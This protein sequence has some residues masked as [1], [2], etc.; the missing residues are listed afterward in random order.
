MQC[1]MNSAIRIRV[2]GSGPVA[3]RV[4][5]AC[6]GA[7]F[8][9]HTSAHGEAVTVVVG[10][11]ADV[12]GVHAPV[13]LVC[14]DFGSAEQGLLAAGAVSDV[15]SADASMGE[16]GARIR[17][18]WL[19]RDEQLADDWKREVDQLLALIRDIA[20]V[21]GGLPS[22]LHGLVSRLAEAAGVER[23]SLVLVDSPNA[24][25]GTV[26]ATSDAA[27][28]QEIH[29][30]LADYPEVREAL[31]TGEPVIVADAAHH[32]LLDGVRA[33]LAKAQVGAVAVF[34]L[35][36]GTDM[37][38][39]L[40][41]RSHEM[42]KRPER[43]RLATTAAVATAIAVRHGRL[44]E[45]V[46]DESARQFER[47][48]DLIEHLSDGVAVIDREGRIVLLNPAGVA[49]FG[50]PTTYLG[51][52]VLDVVPPENPA[53]LLLMWRAINRGG[54]V[55]NADI[56]V[57]RANGQKAIVAVSA[58]Q[59]RRQRLVV[60]SFRDVTEQR[61][62]ERELR[63]TRDFLE[64]VIDA[65]SDAIVASDL[66]GNLL[67]FNRAAG[68]IFGW[69]A[70]QARSDITVRDL[71]PSGGA[72]EIMRLLREAP[73]G[74]IESERIVGRTS[75][76]DDFPVEL[77]AAIIYAGGQEVASVGV[78]RDLRERVRVEGELSRARAKL[79]NAEKHAAIT[80][81]AGATAHELNQP[82]TVL[83]GHVELL[84][85]RSLDGSA[86][87]SFE[88]IGAETERMAAI[89]KRIARLTRVETMPY[90]GERLI[91]DLERSSDPTSD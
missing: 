88:A 56:T 36:D 20:T 7:A 16:L 63:R 46:R 81:L 78:L 47:Y 61:M 64:R 53:E 26:V 34:P 25:V 23:C 45:A 35:R 4:R 3:T 10:Q 91:A 40:M 2:A 65:S 86:R 83:L 58:G 12:E 8:T 89:V 62:T 52:R 84:R 59:L 66:K 24:D 33:R 51:E 79:L 22:V 85:R 37:L 11:A 68:R 87:R 19:Q 48:S 57:T 42:L 72:R 73:G 21:P 77:S 74:H 69:T 50:D 5:E 28:L 55:L 29:I 82:L 41:M 17:R 80:A 6:A 76:G 30:K 32:P 31:R 9:E 71:Y 54:R 60:L 75:T 67:V 27:D 39:V 38:G 15:V 49:I 44:V 1:V 90:P 14:H 43:L 13:V 70:E 18:A